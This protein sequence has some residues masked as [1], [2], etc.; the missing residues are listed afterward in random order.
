MGF[1][2]ASRHGG[3]QLLGGAFSLCII[4]FV[5]LTLSCAT[6][7]PAP[8]SVAP[9][10]TGIVHLD[11][12]LTLADPLP[13]ED[14]LQVFSRVALALD[15]ADTTNVMPLVNRVDTLVRTELRNDAHASVVRTAMWFDLAL[16]HEGFLAGARRSVREALEVPTAEWT[17]EEIS[18]LLLGLLKH[19]LRSPDSEEQITR[20]VLDGIYLIT[21]DDVRAAALVDAAELI[22][23]AEDRLNLNPV[24][25]QAIA[26]IPTLEDP[27]EAAVLTMRLSDLSVT[28]NR[29]R[30]VRNL[31]DLAI[32][33]SEAGL[34]VR[35]DRLDDLERIID[36]AVHQGDRPG[37]E[38][39]IQ[40]A[41]PVSSRALGL[42]FLARSSARWDARLP[43]EGYFESALVTA[44]SI[45]DHVSRART[46][47]RII[48]GR[49]VIDLHWSP[50]AAMADLLGD[51]N[52]S[53]FEHTDR[54]AVLA[55]FYAGYA[56]QDDL[57]QTGRLRGLIRS[58]DELA[59][60]YLNAAELLWAVQ[61]RQAVR[62]LLTQIT[63]IPPAEPGAP[64]SPAYRAAAVWAAIGAYDRAVPFLLEA[65]SR[66]TALILSSIPAGYRF[67]PGA[68]DILERLSP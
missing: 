62:D 56:A 55:E 45:D 18:R 42:A 36:I 59:L 1:R 5:L 47:A 53:T 54:I 35:P 2:S 40:N 11:I 30:D 31:R 41:S 24:V 50:A 14:R 21:R 17:P 48:R 8:R 26:I 25:Q 63:R 57:Q 44:G 3:H 19:Q 7:R 22:R 61:C 6:D 68:V 37:A 46:V 58:A 10:Q 38:V 15:S 52:L 67:N 9:V 32:R 65:T 16:E 43:F 34:L 64:V 23:D 27:M 51:V 20:R 66:E 33:A 29:P 28:L 60:I 12:A 4:I 49:Q 39:M 13:A